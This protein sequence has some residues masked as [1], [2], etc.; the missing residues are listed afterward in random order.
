MAGTAR[1]VAEHHGDL[2]RAA[3]MEARPLLL[4][5]DKP[6]SLPRLSEAASAGPAQL[7]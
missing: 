3:L 4:S 6:N 5:R 7:G 2:I 1:S